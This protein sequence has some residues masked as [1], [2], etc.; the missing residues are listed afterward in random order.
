MHNSSLQRGSFH[1]CI[2]ALF[3]G[4]IIDI[5]QIN[6]GSRKQPE[7]IEWHSAAQIN[8]CMLFCGDRRNLV[9]TVYGAQF[10]ATKNVNLY[11]LPWNS[12][13]D[14]K[15]HAQVASAF[16]LQMQSYRLVNAVFSQVLTKMK[17]SFVGP[18]IG[19]RAQFSAR[20]ECP[21]FLKIKNALLPFFAVKSLIRLVF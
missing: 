18:V 14:L 7:P 17:A 21:R 13:E 3:C 11:F 15:F 10:S 16:S 6:A 2:A 5:S 12:C 4:G 20:K 8:S 9:R 19:Q 1:L